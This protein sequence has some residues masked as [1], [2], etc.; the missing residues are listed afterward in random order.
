MAHAMF[1]QIDFSILQSWSKMEAELD[2]ETK[3]LAILLKT[4]TDENENQQDQ[5]S[6]QDNNV[7]PTKKKRAAYNN[8]KVKARNLLTNVAYRRFKITDFN[9]TNF[10]VD[11]LSFLVQNCNPT[12]LEIKLETEKERGMVKFMWDSCILHDFTTY[13]LKQEN[14]DIISQ[15]NLTYQNANKVV[16]DYVKTEEGRLARLKYKLTQK[17]NLIHYIYSILYAKMYNRINHFDIKRK[18]DFDFQFQLWRKEKQQL[19]FLGKEPTNYLNR[20]V[21]KEEQMPIQDSNITKKNQK[22]KMLE[23]KLEENTKAM[24]RMKRIKSDSK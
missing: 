17:F 16:L 13:L 6:S 18:N 9:K 22:R 20:K 11:I 7:D 23:E 15:T 4:F 14:Y 3:D 21:E 5:N 24:K 10:V 8:T 12:N 2:Q 1:N 19:K